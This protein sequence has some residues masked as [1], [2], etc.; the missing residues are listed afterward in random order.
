MH[1]PYHPRKPHHALLMSLVLPGFGQLYNGCANRGIF[2]FLGFVIL[3]GPSLAVAAL[4]LPAPWTVLVSAQSLLSALAIWIYGMV[5][6]WRTAKRQTDY[7]PLAWQ[8]SGVYVL[9]FLVCNTVALP[10]VIGYVRVHQV[11]AYRIPSGS[12]APGILPGDY[13]FADMRYNC[14]GC[15][16]AVQRGDVA[17]FTYPNNRTLSYI[18]R[19]IGL[20]GDRIQIRGPDVLVNGKLLQKSDHPAM[21]NAALTERYDN[22]SWK[23]VWAVGAPRVPDVDVVVP[24]GQAFVMGD[25]RNGSQDSRSFGTVALQDIVGKAMQIWFSIDP[26][27]GVRWDRMGL[28]V[29]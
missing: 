18:K 4:Y 14:P 8:L 29:E 22:R 24:P 10:A 6:A 27:G 11:A 25:N 19:V 21:R 1:T 20:P 7:T 15:Q 23:V 26:E 3:S 17:I 28:T 16:V 12:M 9:I 5:D 2:L 13:L